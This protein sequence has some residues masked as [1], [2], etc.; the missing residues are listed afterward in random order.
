MGLMLNNDSTSSID[1]NTEYGDVGRCF[2]TE[3]VD[4]SIDYPNN[5]LKLESTSDFMLVTGVPLGLSGFVDYDTFTNKYPD[6][7]AMYIVYEPEE[8]LTVDVI[9]I[10]KN[11]YKEKPAIVNYYWNFYLENK[12][13]L[14]REITDLKDMTPSELK[15]FLIKYQEEDDYN[16]FNQRFSSKHWDE[17]VSSV[18]QQY[19]NR[20]HRLNFS[21]ITNNKEKVLDMLSKITGK[22][23]SDNIKRNYDLYLSHQRLPKNL[24][25]TICMN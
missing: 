9:N 23:I 12:N 10:Y 13:I 8:K 6:W 24:I 16:I 22:E 14:D 25:E 4:T 7:L 2:L 18:P 15:T 20:I 3:N 11:F 21:D 19:R 1:I 17:F 5:F